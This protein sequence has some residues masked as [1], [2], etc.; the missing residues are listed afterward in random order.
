MKNREAH[1]AVIGR[2]LPE[3]GSNG[4]PPPTVFEDAAL[5]KRFSGAIR[6]HKDDF[7]LGLP[8]RFRRPG[9]YLPLHA[10]LLGH[11]PAE[12][13]HHQPVRVSSYMGDN[14]SLIE[15]GFGEPPGC[16]ALDRD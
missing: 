6:L 3:L 15:D 11:H 10:V 2:F 4:Q 16:G 7:D 14:P 1:W 8:R 9:Y 5:L 13:E 12:E